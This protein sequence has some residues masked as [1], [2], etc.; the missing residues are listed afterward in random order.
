VAF[1]VVY[2]ACVLFPAPLRDLLIRVARTGVVRAHW[3]DNILDECFR[4]ILRERDDL[5]PDALDR[6]RL[7]M[8]TALPDARVTGHERLIDS[9][10]LPDPEDRHVLA[11]AVRIG[12]QAIVTFNLKDF[13]SVALEPLGIEAKHPDDFLVEAIDLAPGAIAAAVNEQAA[14]LKNP[15]RTVADLLDTLQRQG[16]PLSVARL[17]EAFGFPR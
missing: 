2:D 10:E 9:F 3:S 15:A 6:T 12:A 4:S 7:L 11:A 8:N 16:L 1:I 5:A 13:P 17:R 14:T